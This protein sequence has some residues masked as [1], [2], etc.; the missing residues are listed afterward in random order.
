MARYRV[1]RGI[2]GEGG[3]PAVRDESGK[4]TAPAKPLKQYHKGS[5]DGDIVETD[6]DLCERFNIPDGPRKFDR[7]P[8]APVNQVALDT[9][10]VPELRKHAEG[11]EIDLGTATRRDEILN[12]IHAA[13]DE[14]Q[15]VPG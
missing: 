3:T 13:M 5:D 7:L 1:L 4:V 2:H 14:A 8:D 6:V 15:P 12:T 9:M 10:T 11:E